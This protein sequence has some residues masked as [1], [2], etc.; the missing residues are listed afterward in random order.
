M[1]MQLESKQPYLENYLNVYNKAIKHSMWIC[2][3]C[4]IV[5][6]K[7]M[8]SCVWFVVT[9]NLPSAH[10]GSRSL[11]WSG[12]L[13]V[14]PPQGKGVSSFCLTNILKWES[15]LLPCP[16]N[17]EEELKN[18]TIKLSHMNVVIFG[19]C[20]FH[21]NFTAQAAFSGMPGIHCAKYVHT[22]N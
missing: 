19:S 2:I 6:K 4:L 20:I 11:G 16:N 13:C 14:L 22:D 12:S 17:F 1:K 9:M 18:Y 10:L 15:L 3:I 21:I 7:Y 5:I 8:H